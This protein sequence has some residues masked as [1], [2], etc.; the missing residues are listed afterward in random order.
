MLHVSL[1]HAVGIF[2]SSCYLKLLYCIN[3]RS[4]Q[5]PPS[6]MLPLEENIIDASHSTR[7]VYDFHDGSDRDEELGLSID[8]NPKKSRKGQSSG[9]LK[10]KLPGN[11]TRLYS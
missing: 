9:S 6:N 5:V 7:S 1:T 11:V 2:K 3:G 4:Q 8:E 10:V